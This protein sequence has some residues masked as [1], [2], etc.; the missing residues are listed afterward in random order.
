M[1]CK[2]QAT[3]ANK[4]RRQGVNFFPWI[5]PVHNQEQG[6]LRRGNVGTFHAQSQTESLV[7]SLP[8]PWAGHFR[9]D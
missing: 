8:V 5:F 1:Y 9:P 7:V 3:R 4:R 2:V 6:R